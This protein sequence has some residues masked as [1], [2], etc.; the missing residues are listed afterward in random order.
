MDASIKVADLKASRGVAWLVEAF[1]LFRRA[2][3]AWIGLCAGWI[4]ITFGLILLP[5]IGGVLANFLQPVFFASFAIAA[6]RQAAGERVVMADLFAAF[7]RNMRPL[8]NLGALLLLAE[9]AIFALMALMG[10]PMA[11][12]SD[13]SFTLTEYVDALKG[14][15]WILS[16]GF[17]MT[18]MVKGAL[19][20][21][22]PLI[23]FHGMT[24]LQAIRWSVFAAISNLGAM[25]VYGAML[26][27]LFIVALM[28]W[29]L[30]LI[31]LIPVMV[32]STYVGYRDVFET[33]PK[34]VSG[35]V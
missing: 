2:P 5:F 27:F 3:L 6:Y 31:V 32:V 12:S 14:K 9:I 4:A 11:A 23:A 33:D 15:E 34:M 13:R 24:T 10:L 16:V 8:V 29:A 19:W 28:P 35:T 30:G 1:A 25:M 22:P 20:F 26:L 21:A 17:L 18:V 7:K